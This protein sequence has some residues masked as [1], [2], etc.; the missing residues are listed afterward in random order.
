M[1]E[2]GKQFDYVKNANEA[3]SLEGKNVVMMD[4]D[5]FS[6]NSDITFTDGQAA[7]VPQEFNLNGHTANYV[8]TFDKG[9]MGADDSNWNTV[10]FPFDHSAVKAGEETRDRFRDTTDADKTIWQGDLHANY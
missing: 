1:N 10:V 9:N 8:R 6:A 2:A 3:A 7:F 5:A 4:G